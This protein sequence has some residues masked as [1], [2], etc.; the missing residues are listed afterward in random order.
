MCIF[1][2]FT[3]LH[4]T[5]YK[6]LNFPWYLRIL[7]LHDVMHARKVAIIAD[8]S[9]L[10]NPDFRHSRKQCDRRLRTISLLPG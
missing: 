4:F 9:R 5:V 1:F 10:P 8:I 2:I 6:E 3:F 7:P